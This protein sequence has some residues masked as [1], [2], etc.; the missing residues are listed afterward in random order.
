MEVDQHERGITHALY[1]EVRASGP[2][3]RDIPGPRMNRTQRTDDGSDGGE[4]APR[5]AVRRAP[6]AARGARP[7]A[8]LLY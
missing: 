4:W 8:S 6:S 3:A 2:H 5:H 1:Q 7:P